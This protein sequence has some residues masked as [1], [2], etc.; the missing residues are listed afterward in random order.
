MKAEEEPNTA[1]FLFLG[2]AHGEIEVLRKW[3][4]ISNLEG[5]LKLTTFA[6]RR[7]RTDRKMEPHFFLEGKCKIMTFATRRDRT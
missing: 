5:N 4:L 1:E 3:R 2:F 6:T 7:D